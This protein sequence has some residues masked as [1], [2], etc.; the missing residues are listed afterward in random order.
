MEAK[1]RKLILT[2]TILYTILVLYFL[3]FAFN[4][5]D[6]A[7][8]IYGYV[9]MLVPEA[10]PLQF[11]QLTFSW[12]Y[13]FGNVA[14]FIPFGLLIPL[15]YRVRFEKFI[16]LFVLSILVLETLQSLTHLGS[17]DVDDVISNTLGA[18]IGFIAYRVGFSSI[19]SY[20]KLIV[21]ALSIVVLLIGIM[22]ISETI[23]YAIEK[24]EGPIQALTDAK[25]ITGTM[26]MTENLP[27][28]TIKSKRIKPKMNMYGSEGNRNKKY[29]YILGNKKDVM[30]Y[31]Y[32]GIPDNVDFK[33]EVTIIADGNLIAQYNEKYNKEAEAL[34]I[35]FDKINEITIIVSG[36]AKLWDVGFSEMKHWWVN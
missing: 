23:N 10:V 13:D 30:F 14:A 32:Y 9:F 25:E 22:V 28:F 3:F 5:V 6:H 35:P 19:I 8:D 18:V 4:R 31:S 1:L 15:L 2:G 17:F 21:S 26:P 11:P 24:R 7:S 16:S 20:K 33:G 36:N 29:T 27:S 34:N 12:I